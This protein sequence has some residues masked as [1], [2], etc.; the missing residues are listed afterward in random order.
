VK[1]SRQIDQER[2]EKRQFK[3]EAEKMS[4]RLR[5]NE[6]ELRKERIRRD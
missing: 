3:S 6:E 5:F 4:V 2:T 1:F